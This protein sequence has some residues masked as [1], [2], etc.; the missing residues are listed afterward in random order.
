MLSRSIALVLMVTGFLF[1][2]TAC[3]RPASRGG[4]P[5]ALG[6]SQS[7]PQQVEEDEPTQTPFS[8]IPDVQALIFDTPTPNPPLE[9]PELRVDP[10]TYVVQP[11]DTLMRIARL[12]SVSIEQIVNFNDLVNPD[13]L[14]VGQVLEIPAPVPLDPGPGFKI[15]PNS[16][17]IDSPAAANFD[18][19]AVVKGLGGYLD[20]YVEEVNGTEISGAEIVEMVSHNYS[21]NPRLLLALLEHQSQWL[22]SAN[23]GTRDYPL[24]L[25]DANRKGLYRQLTWAADNLNQGYYLWRVNAL[26]AFV[27]ADGSLVP[28]NPTINE[29]TAGIQYFFSRLYGLQ[30]WRSAVKQQ[31]L[32]ATY[33]RLFGFP[34]QYGIDPLLPEAL[35]QPEFRLP[36]EDGVVWS[37]TGGPHGGWADGSAWAALDFAPPGN[38]LGC[39]LSD[40]W[41]VAVA[42]GIITHTGDGQVILDLDGDG[43]HHTGWTVFY[44]HIE[45]RDRIAPGAVVKAG[46]RIGHPSCEGGF[47]TGTH[48]HIA[49]KY[50]GEWIPADQGNVPFIMDGWVSTG[51]GYVYDG[52]LV[53]G[54]RS[55]I[56]EN[57]RSEENEIAR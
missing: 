7:G 25:T 57:G 22:T 39:I 47:S 3:I 1:A 32:F 16:E 21:V 9:L 11:G 53:K 30:E 49:R 12:F 19:S 55:I 44:M 28:A 4:E 31:G 41:V 20:G 54:N 15:I 52:W 8:P 43:N 14:E 27:L 46:E 24:G 48:L 40:A 6:N 29:G 26:P 34:F 51:S 35:E 56:A 36:F 38:A 18:T 23:P 5:W 13:F 42:D 37:F 45:S 17:L 10:E 2:A 50:N 33:M